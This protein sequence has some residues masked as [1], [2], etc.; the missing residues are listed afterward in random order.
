ML[1]RLRRFQPSL[2]VHPTKNG[3]QLSIEIAGERVKTTIPVAA[4]SEWTP[5]LIHSALVVQA[6][7]AGISI[8]PHRVM[9]ARVVLDNSRVA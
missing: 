9:I 4:F 7:E 1:R 3:L 8:A 2:I 6:A 5:D